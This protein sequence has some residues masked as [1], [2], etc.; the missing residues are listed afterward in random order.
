MKPTPKKLRIFLA[1]D[2]AMIRAGLKLL[3]NAQSDMEVVGEAGDGRTAVRL[4][5]ELQPDVVVMDV[6]MPELN[7]LQATEQLKKARAQI[8]ILPLTRHTDGGY[9]QQ[10][11]GAGA[12]G[13]MLKQSV[14]EEL[15]RAIRSIA[16]GGTY[17]DPAVAGKLITSHPGRLSDRS[18]KKQ[19]D[20]TERETEVLRLIAWGHSNKEIASQLNLSVKTVEAHK[21]N[22]MKKL[23]LHSRIDIMR[24]AILQDWL[25]E[26]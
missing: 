7:G 3:V 8:K 15:I 11:L 16:A 23:D 22:A 21:A 13:Y 26:N 19:N 2:H 4:A 9:L 18:A 17:L 5:L 10:L 14:A 20:L 6:S 12:S 25:R 1:D 24:Y